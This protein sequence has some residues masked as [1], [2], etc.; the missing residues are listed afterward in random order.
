MNDS[1][2]PEWMKKKKAEQESASVKEEA[3]QQRAVTFD[4]LLIKR[5]S[6]KFW[7]ELQQKLEIAVRFLPELGLTGSTSPLGDGVRV[8]V[9][10]PGVLPIQ[11]H[12]DLF[13]TQEVGGIR[14][15]GLNIGFYILQFR[16]TPDKRVAVLS[17]RG[18]SD[19][20]N[21]EQACEH[22]MQVMMDLIDPKK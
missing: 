10:C 22:V 6:R 7:K 21:P 20:M 11:T 14:C 19:L 1:L 2:M 17:S 4:S 18:G 12:T 5:D 15:S 8:A 13:W 9:S 16:V 3:R